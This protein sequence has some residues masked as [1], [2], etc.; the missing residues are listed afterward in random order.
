MALSGE[1]GCRERR[2]DITG[3]IIIRPIESEPE[4]TACAEMMSRSDPWVTLGRDYDASLNMLNAS[5]REVYVAIDHEAGVIGFVV[6]VMSGAFRGYIQSLAV[7]P[8][9]RN[10]GIGLQ[11]M[12]F[13]ENRIFQESPNI[14]ICV[15]SFNPRARTFYERLGYQVVGELKEY[16]IPGHSEILLRKTLGPLNAF[17]KKQPKT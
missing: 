7:S 1:S 5:D 4:R 11:L 3:S 10:R 8:L 15:S 2:N 13:A 9:H 14:F 17:S 16:I 6:I 12:D